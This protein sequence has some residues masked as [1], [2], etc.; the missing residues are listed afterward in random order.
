MYFSRVR[1]A[2]YNALN[3]Q[4]LP[5]MATP[6]EEHQLLWQLFDRDPGAKRDFLFRRDQDSAL[7]SFYL[8]SERK[9]GNADGRWQIETKDYHPRLCAGQR[10]AFSLRANPVVTR[11]DAQGKAHRHDLVM[12]LKTRS[13]WKKQTASQRP[14]LAELMQ[15]A[16]EQWLV[17]R[18]AKAGA[19]LD[20]LRVE[21]YQQHQ[22]R[23]RDKGKPIRF[24]T[25]DL[26]GLLTVDDPD[27]FG[28]ALY[29]GIGPAKAFGCGLLLV[30]SV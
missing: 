4:S 21:A 14:A 16:G 8:L 11:K 17:D 19:R 9:P 18:L 3:N 1:L 24:S 27:R 15:Q 7:P 6:Y 10:L 5:P 26:T 20:S 25:L 23:K 30:K 22:H 12:D 13:G 28:W 29:H 2:P